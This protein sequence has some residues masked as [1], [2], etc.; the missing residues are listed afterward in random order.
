[1]DANDIEAHIVIAINLEQKK[2]YPQAIAEL[3]KAYELA[4]QNPLILGPLGSCYGGSGDTEKAL[5][6]L[7]KLNEAVKQM[8]VAPMSWVMLYLGVGDT[9]N[10]FQWLEKAAEARDILLYY[11][12][13]GPIYDSIRDDPRYGDLLSRIGLS[14]ADSISRLRTVTQHSGQAV[15]SGRGAGESSG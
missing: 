2:E 6:L 7:D 3:E 14:D 11:L 12:K 15:S 1:M 8:Y 9:D 5:S 13:V 10:A 4:G